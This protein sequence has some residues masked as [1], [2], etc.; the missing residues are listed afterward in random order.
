[1]CAEREETEVHPDEITPLLTCPM[2]G[3]SR[4]EVQFQADGQLRTEFPRGDG[5]ACARCK[6][7]LTGEKGLP[8]TTPEEIVA[9]I[10]SAVA[11]QEHR[12]RIS[13]WKWKAEV[14]SRVLA[15]PALQEGADPA[16]YFDL[17]SPMLKEDFEAGKTVDQVFNEVDERFNEWGW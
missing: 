13:F 16:V 9:L 2:C 6:R 11:D 15:H 3:S 12:E 17:D 4:F 1:M 5:F 10:D 14:M 7:V 8:A